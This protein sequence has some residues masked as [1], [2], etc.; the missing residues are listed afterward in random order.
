MHARG[1]PAKRVRL[2]SPRYPTEEEIIFP[3]LTVLEVTGMRVD[4]TIIIAEV[5]PS[6]P[7]PSAATGDEDAIRQ[8]EEKLKM[9]SDMEAAMA[10]AHAAQVREAET[11]HLAEKTKW[12]SQMTSFISATRDAQATSMKIAAEEARRSSALSE[13]EKAEKM[14]LLEEK[15]ASFAKATGEAQS[16]VDKAAEEAAHLEEKVTRE[17][18]ALV[19]N[20]RRSRLQRQQSMIRCEAATLSGWYESAH[21]LG[22]RA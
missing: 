3:P 4:G 22:K 12:K 17:R 18:T 19:E 9:V 6:V 20:M 13:A 8:H 1:L 14:R 5:S 10:E 2:S 21:V 16:L 11:R 15:E 7:K